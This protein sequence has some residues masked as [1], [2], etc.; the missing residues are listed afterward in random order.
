MDV[1]EN[2]SREGSVSSRELKSF[3]KK[4]VLALLV[5][6]IVG[7]IVSVVIGVTRGEQSS[8]HSESEGILKVLLGAS[9]SNVTRDVFKSSD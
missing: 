3:R 7:N 5:L 6:F 4:L 9:T 2:V 1:T 8:T